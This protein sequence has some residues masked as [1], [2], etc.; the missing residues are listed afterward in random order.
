MAS[1]QDVVSR[2]ARRIEGIELP[3]PTR[4][5]IDGVDAAGKTILADEIAAEIASSGRHVI[6]ASIDGFHNPA[7]IRRRRGPDSP[8]GYFRDS[9]NYHAL[10][11]RL[12][13]PL[14]PS[15]SLVFQRAVFDFRTDSAVDRSEEGA[16]RDSILIFDGVFLLREEIRDRW[17]LSIF[18]RASFATTVSRA[19][20]R[21]QALF[22]TRQEVQ[23]RYETRYVP[24]QQLYLTEV[25]PETLAD[26]VLVNDDPLSPE[27]DDAA[28]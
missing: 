20:E 4:V 7:A 12:L 2:L 16:V 18:V 15:G 17:D 6:R 1:R 26:I 10:R 25:K 5:G 9:F 21:D 11:D 28:F 23:R 24:G 13:D 8:E 14:G 22:G 3:H 19:I 27:L